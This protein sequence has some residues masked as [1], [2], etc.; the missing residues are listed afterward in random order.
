MTNAIQKKRLLFIEDVEIATMQTS[1]DNDFKTSF[2]TSDGFLYIGYCLSGGWQ[3]TSTNRTHTGVTAGNISYVIGSDVEWKNTFL[4]GKTVSGLSLCIPYEKVDKL[5]GHFSLSELEKQSKPGKKSEFIRLSHAPQQVLSSAAAIFS[6]QTGVPEDQLLLE[7]NILALLHSSFS[8]L[9][10]YS[11]PQS[12]HAVRRTDKERLYYVRDLIA[13]NL[14]NPL[15]IAEL[16]LQCGINEH[17]LKQ[18]FKLLF[19]TTIYNYS[20]KLRFKEARR[21]IECENCSVTEAATSVGY[22]SFGHFS[23]SYHQYFG[24]FP[25]D[26]ARS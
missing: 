17:K 25:K 13:S 22:Y 4:K 7:S 26:T 10:G 14:E 16:A 18:S 2:T 15:S 8:L 3:T 5:S 12:S 19:G 21:L 23:R 6:A 1:C 20:K 9:S 11:Q 24:F